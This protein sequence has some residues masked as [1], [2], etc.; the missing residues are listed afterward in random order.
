M[1][2]I[3][4][5]DIFSGYTADGNGFTIPLAAVPGLTAAEAHAT[6]GDARELLRLL[7]EKFFAAI[8]A[9]PTNE[10][11]L[12]MTISRGALVGLTTSTVRRSYSISFDESVGAV[13]TSIRPEP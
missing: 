7:L 10:K 1:A 6:T 8:E 9:M 13:A 4:P 3:Q 12:Y 5:T 11:P 2:A